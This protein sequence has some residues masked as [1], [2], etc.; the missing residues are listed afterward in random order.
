[1]YPDRPSEH[2]GMSS[3]YGGEAYP[4]SVRY[5]WA[6]DLLEWFDYYLKGM[7]PKPALHV[8]VQDNR[9]NWRIE[10]TYPP[11]GIQWQELALGSGMELVE[12][13]N[14]LGQPL[15]TPS[16]GLVFES[17]DTFAAGT[18]ISGLPQFHVTVTP[19]G[20]GGQLFAQLQDAKS[21]LR[22]G[23]AIMDL[24]F[25]A[26]GKDA[27]SVV[28]GQPIVA[29]MEFQAMDIVLEEDTKLRLVLEATGED[30]LPSPVSDPVLVTVGPESV[31]RLSQL[32]PPAE[33][34]FEPPAFTPE[35]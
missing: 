8:E 28:P 30:Y 18:R 29:R 24:R 7:G 4:E 26:G 3:G 35:D 21:G 11:R 19:G 27:S 31:L 22:L 23:H 34:F 17:K 14:E 9:G 1:M 2:D 12:V 5:D 16:G 25:H 6:Q 13:N 15:V 32:T 10:E 20:P 33:A